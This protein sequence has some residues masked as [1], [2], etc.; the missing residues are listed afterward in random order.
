MPT[1]VVVFPTMA[2]ENQPGGTGSFR[3]LDMGG[4]AVLF[5]SRLAT[6]TVTARRGRPLRLRLVMRFWPEVAT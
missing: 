5:S 1:P 2:G 3:R 6:A 4:V